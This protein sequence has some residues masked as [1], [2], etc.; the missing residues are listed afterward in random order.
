MSTDPSFQMPVED[1]F[2]IRGRGTVVTGR[3]EAGTLKTGDQVTLQ[4]GGASRT[5]TVTGIEMF[6]KVL[7][8]AGPGDNVGLLLRDITKDDVQRGD[9]LLGAGDNLGGQDYTWKP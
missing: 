9:L 3:V 6:R 8:Q 2:F 1:V 5:V 4:H 7:D